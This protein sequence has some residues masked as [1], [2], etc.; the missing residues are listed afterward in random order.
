MMKPPSIASW[1]LFAE[2]ADGIVDFG[3]ALSIGPHLEGSNPAAPLRIPRPEGLD[4]ALFA[5]SQ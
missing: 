2:G 3:G 5:T 4:G 1:L